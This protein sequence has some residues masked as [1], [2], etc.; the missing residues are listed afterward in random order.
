MPFHFLIED[1]ELDFKAT[2]LTRTSFGAGDEVAK[3]EI[4]DLI[5]KRGRLEGALLAR[6]KKWIG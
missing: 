3:L 2:G 6:F 5:R 1:T 4:S